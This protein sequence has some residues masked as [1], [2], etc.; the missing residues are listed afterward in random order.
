M[1]DQTLIYTAIAIYLVIMLLIGYA[2]YRKTTGHED[3][4]V[5][6]RALPPWVAALS[7]GASDS[8][9]WIMMGLPGAVYL[10]GLVEAWIAVGLGIGVYVNWK[11]IAPRL[12]AYSQ[13]SKN[14]ITL[15]SFFEN[16]TRDKTRILRI[17]AGVIV[18]VFFTLYVSSGMVAGGVFVEGSLGGNYMV[19]MLIVSG[20]TILYTLVGGFLAA[21]WT[22]VVQGIMMVLALIA[23]PVAALFAVGGIGEV[24]STVNDIDPSYFSLVGEGLSTA[25]ILTIVSGLAWGL[26]Y[27][28]QPHILV[29]FM[30]LRSSADARRGRHIAVGWTYVLML[31]SILSGIIGLAYFTHSGGSLDN[32]ETVVLVLA[33][34]LLHP[35]VAG[36]IL[37]AVL[38]AIMSTMSSQLIVTSSALI[39]DLFKVAR[40]NPPPDHTL[41]VYGRVGVLVIAA[42]A[43]VLALSPSDTILGLVSFAWAGFGA[44]FGPIVLLSLLWRKLTN[45]GALAGM[46]VGAASVFGWNAL[47]TGLYE[48][49]P[50]FILALVTTMAV[51]LITYQ[52]NEEIETEFAA[53]S[54]LVATEKAPRKTPTDG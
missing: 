20:V 19:G 31:G 25:T 7:S 9:G 4:M 21:S 33:Q 27:I 43:A 17:V 24:T 6:G 50:A 46:I 10:G 51:S 3:Y 36:F 18:L 26:G 40:K 47:D 13:V 45:W 29:R 32:P 1:S 54:E 14:S 12:R 8:S 11:V 39:E 42:V 34:T 37:A 35:L 44:A 49:L 41:L 52:R 28:G 22:D 48:L 53:S 38:A 15:P 2:A 30:A 5:G 16:R 23:V